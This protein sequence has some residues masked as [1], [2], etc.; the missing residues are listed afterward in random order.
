METF[1][2]FCLE[3]ASNIYTMLISFHNAYFGAK[4]LPKL[5]FSHGI[6]NA[7]QLHIHVFTQVC[8]NAPTSSTQPVYSSLQSLPPGTLHPE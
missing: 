2:I 5:L 1:A 4:Q 8:P 3:Q 6:K 7:V